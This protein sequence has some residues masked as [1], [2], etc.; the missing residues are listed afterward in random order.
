MCVY[1]YKQRSLTSNETTDSRRH[2]WAR[3]LVSRHTWARTIVSQHT[4]ARILEFDAYMG[5][6]R[7]GSRH[8]RAHTIEANDGRRERR[9]VGEGELDDV[10]TWLLEQLLRPVVL[11]VD[12][13]LRA[14][15]VL[16]L[17]QRPL[18]SLF[19]HTQTNT[20]T[21]KHYPL[22]TMTH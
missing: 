4:W 5:T 3:T 11:L 8:T 6:Y 19:L 13:L 17:R 22:G 21:Y 18:L 9:R 7:R 14:V 10:V 12:R 16:F 20:N 15:L 1:V 2:T